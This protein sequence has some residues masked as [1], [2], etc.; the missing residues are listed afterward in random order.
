MLGELKFCHKPTFD[1]G[2]PGFLSAPAE[3][4]GLCSVSESLLEFISWGS[5][6][7]VCKR[8]QS[9]NTKIV[10]CTPTREPWSCYDVCVKAESA[11]VGSVVNV[12]MLLPPGRR[13]GSCRWK[14]P[15][16]GWNWGGAVTERS[17]RC[18]GSLWASAGPPGFHQR[19]TDVGVTC[20]QRVCQALEMMKRCASCTETAAGWAG[21]R[22]TW[23]T[24]GQW[25]SSC[26]TTG[27]AWGPGW[28]TWGTWMWEVMEVGWG[29][30]QTELQVHHCHW[31]QCWQME[32]PEWKP[33]LWALRCE[34]NPCEPT[35]ACQDRMLNW[36]RWRIC[37][38]TTTTT[39]K[40]EVWDLCKQNMHENDVI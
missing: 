28:L 17:R 5:T 29:C 26:L 19:K 33:Q 36:T 24:L 25:R 39:T 37:E 32:G 1:V 8:T 40:Y 38:G 27:T 23:L 15:L 3:R 31:S 20:L 16:S 6:R 13:R 11:T 14:F 22:W 12:Q 18:P 4:G 7:K 10:F 2:M 21:R 35:A 34:A 30:P 9:L